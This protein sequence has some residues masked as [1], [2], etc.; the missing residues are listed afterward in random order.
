MLV[1]VA[2]RFGT[3][4][5]PVLAQRPLTR[6]VPYDQWFVTHLDDRS[7]VKQVKLWMLSKCNLVPSPGPYTQ[8]SVSPIVFAS[9]VRARSSLDSL[10]DGYNEDDEYSDQDLPPPIYPRTPGPSPQPVNSPLVD[11][12]T[13]L[14]FSTGSILEDEFAISWYS[15]RPYELLEMHPVG[16][17]APLQRHVLA[18]YIQP[19]F[20]AKV[21]VL[22]A[23]W[24]HRSGRFEAPRP[25]AHSGYKAMDKLAHRFDSFSTKS[26]SSQSEKQRRAKLDWK[27]RCLVINQGSLFLCKEHVVHHPLHALRHALSAPFQTNPPLDQFAL[28]A[29]TAL[30]GADAFERAYSF[31]TQ[32]RLVCINF[33]PRSASL[34]GVVSPP[35]SLPSSP[36]SEKNIQEDSASQ[37][38]ELEDTGEY[39]DNKGEGEWVVLDMLDDNGQSSQS[40]KREH[41]IMRL[42]RFRVF[43]A[44]S[45]VKLLTRYHRPLSPRHP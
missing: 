9:T 23:V 29:M 24:N 5:L 39:H 22:R 15:L 8:R 28:S 30:R 2:C 6:P 27:T 17:V 41:A 1:P 40:F 31:T 35:P 20:Q 34:S 14:S 45:T 43:S 36:I 21:R 4:S 33:R 16:T 12:Y 11:Q 7:K 32:P 25:D 18:E 19:Y 3:Y 44:F 13:L 38:T 10:D 37:T 26:T 42:Q